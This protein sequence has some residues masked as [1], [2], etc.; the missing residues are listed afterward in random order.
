MASSSLTSLNTLNTTENT[1][2]ILFIPSAF[3][4][5]L[6]WALHLP[7]VV[8][9]Q[10]HSSLQ[11]WFIPLQGKHL[12]EN[13]QYHIL[14]HPGSPRRSSTGVTN[15]PNPA[16]F[17]RSDK[18]TAQGAMAAGQNAVPVNHFLEDHLVW[19]CL[20]VWSQAKQSIQMLKMCNYYWCL[21]N[22]RRLINLPGKTE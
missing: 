8:P 5:H 10:Q 2:L 21:S 3:H 15:R 20:S 16:L 7:E 17:R 6:S 1:G 18:I 19:T 12:P 4:P 14:Q 13:N 22:I 9:F 11:Y